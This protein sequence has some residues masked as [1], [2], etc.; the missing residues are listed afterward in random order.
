MEK[1][2]LS[3]NEYQRDLWRLAAKIRRGDWRPDY[4]VGL[5]R[6][7][8]PVAIAVHEFLRYTGWN[9][10]HLPLK[11]FSYTGIG[12]QASEVGFFAGE[13]V[14]SLFKPG[15]KV[16]FIDDVFDTGKTAEAVLAK[17]RASGADA[18]FAAVYWKKENNATA[19]AP[20][21]VARELGLEW[22]VFPHELEGLTAE[23]IRAKDALLADLMKEASVF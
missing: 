1:T 8:A 15:E 11:C 4:L 20:D 12:E 2:Y 18:R 16:L 5:W 6:G 22:L 9:V 23:E 7:G 21:Y 19:F 13:P 10:S 17:T 14:F 3:A